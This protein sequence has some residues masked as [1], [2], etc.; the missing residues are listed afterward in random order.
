[1]TPSAWRKALISPL[2]VFALV[3]LA[4]LA[5]AAEPPW[6]TAAGAPLA[7]DLGGEEIGAAAVASGGQQLLV[8][9]ET[10]LRVFD[11]AGG[12]AARA[13]LKGYRSPDAVA[14]PLAS[15][16]Q[17]VAAVGGAGG[18]QLLRIDAASGKKQTLAALKREPRLVTATPDGRR[19]AIAYEDHFAQVFDASGRSLMGPAKVVKGEMVVGTLLDRVTALA[20]SPDGNLLAVA[21][22]DVSL[23]LV[24]LAGAKPPLRVKPGPFQGTSHVHSPAKLLAFSADGSRLV[25][26][27]QGGNL[28]LLDG[29]TGQPLSGLVQVRSNVAALALAPEPG[30][31]WLLSPEGQAQLWKWAPR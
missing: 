24:D 8:D 19:I 2:L 31:L 22:E 14:W 15:G 29:H 18:G 12:R 11:L 20:L 26:F 6:I 17:V 16:L 1:M 10:A 13:P 5:R 4:P 28:G 3:G 27:E 21:G 9:G 23:M 30:N 7:L 25:S